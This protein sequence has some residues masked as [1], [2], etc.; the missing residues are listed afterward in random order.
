MAADRE[1]A[2]PGTGDQDTALLTWGCPI[3]SLAG[4]PASSQGEDGVQ[5]PVH[6]TF[7]LVV[8]VG[9]KHWVL[10]EVLQQEHSLYRH[11]VS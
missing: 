4:G 11:W 8:Q 3:S 6:V 1:K 7:K 5:Q 10:S 2:V 9:K